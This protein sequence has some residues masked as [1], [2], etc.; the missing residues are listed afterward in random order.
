MTR[1]RALVL[2]LAAVAV[3]AAVA[4]DKPAPLDPA[5][6]VGDWKIVEGMK[7][8]EKSGDDAKKGMVIVDKEKITLKGDDMTF[9]FSYKIDPKKEPAEI[10]LE[11]VEPEGLKGAKA[12]GIVKLEKEKV[13]LCYHPMMGDRPTKFDSTKENGNYMFTMEKAKKSDK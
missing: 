9:A 4:D 13:T 1:V 7:A 6:L 11:I 3:T 5:K 2:G 10:D 12:K 8:G